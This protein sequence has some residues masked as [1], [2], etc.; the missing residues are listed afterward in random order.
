MY[1]SAVWFVFLQ[2]ALTPVAGL[3]ILV[4]LRV[5]VRTPYLDRANLFR[6]PHQQIRWDRS[7]QMGVNI[8]RQGSVATIPALSPTLHIL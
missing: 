4:W 7:D 8:D 2:V 5:A 1:T 3:G 6:H